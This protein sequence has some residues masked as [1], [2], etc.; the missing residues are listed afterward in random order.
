MLATRLKLSPLYLERPRLLSR[1]PESEG[2]V[3]IL[4]APF[5]YGKSVLAA[6]WADRLEQQGV[7]VVW[8]SLGL[9][10]GPRESLAQ[11]L[12]L[13]GSAPWG[14][15][16]E[17]LANPLTLVVM[18][19]LEGE[20]DDLGPLLRYSQGLLLLASRTSL[21][22]PELLHLA[23]G[24]RLLHLRASDLA[25]TLDEA[26]ALFS[27]P[28]QAESAW[29]A[30][31]GWPLVLH[32][33]ALTGEPPARE[34]LL[35][36]MRQSL[37][38]ALFREALFLAALPYLPHSAV[39]PETE[40]LAGRGFAQALTEGIRLH[41]LVAETLWRAEPERV[42]KAVREEGGR[43]NVLFR[44]YAYERAELWE[45]LRGLLDGLVPSLPEGYLST[46]DPAAFIR[47]DAQVGG[48]RG[49][50]R[51]VRLGESFCRLG[52]FREGVAFLLE[53]AREATAPPR[54]RLE[55]YGMA[56]FF[57]APSHPEEAKAAAEQGLTFL[58]AP[59]VDP[60]LAGRF[61]NDVALVYEASGDRKRALELLEQATQHLLSSTA[62]TAPRMNLA[63]L[64]FEMEGDLEGLILVY[65]EELEAVARYLPQSL[66]EAHLTL[67]RAYKLLAQEE[68]VLKHL[69]AAIREAPRDSL[70]ALEA[71]A[72]WAALRG[73]SE[74]FPALWARAQAW[75]HP[76]LLDRVRGL[77]ARTLRLQGL[78]EEA[79]VVLKDGEGNW[80]AL[81]RALAWEDAAHLPPL[82]REREAQL[83][84]HAARFLLLGT[85][86]DLNALLGL[87]SLGERVLPA[88]LPPQAIASHRPEL[89]RAYP[90]RTLLQGGF[91]EA[92]RQRSH[93]L[94]P[95][96]VWVL[97]RFYIEGPLGPINLSLRLK[98]L[99]GL[100]LL[101]FDAAQLKAALWPEVAPEQARNNLQV[102]LHYLRRALEPWGV[103]T[104]LEEGQLV[105]VKA[106]LE[107]LKSRL[108]ALE[109][110]DLGAA[111]EVLGL[112]QEPLLPGLDL[113]EIDAEREALRARVVRSLMRAGQRLPPEEARVVL[114]RVLE[115]E[116]LEEEALRLLLRSLLDLGRKG[117]ALRYYQRFA[118]RLREELGVEP[119]RETRAL[120]GL[121]PERPS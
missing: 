4:E 115:L 1:L 6:Q 113:P 60:D 58:N 95:L 37:G 79:R 42:K 35:L 41:P 76:A 44:G 121:G 62:R 40:A 78:R 18:E 30:S 53:A 14:V 88:L 3:V 5:G 98:Q 92:I 71:E 25:F 110:G 38:Q 16:L 119:A 66:A 2:S 83:F 28:Q 13:P 102:H 89:L 15:I 81:E 20:S 21:P 91:K 97:G 9:G 112:Y 84:W 12:R 85:E 94:P 63:S 8:V 82:P 118:E 109:R 86:E 101:G 90:L 100:L 17:A 52:R 104:Y 32:L 11:A 61:L 72:E 114:E 96:R 56:A 54:V 47:W 36:G 7:R 64:R 27:D 31:G 46:V 59:D 10:L 120:L 50:R 19:D 80:T 29:R 57:L 77:W 39:R 51:T 107:E 33:T 70:R 111:R 65:E 43:L 34:A 68:L 48:Q 87:T 24:K 26:R 105:R 74:A 69:E 99:F 103:P 75:E 93:E 106:D 67:A 55:A 108:H 117:E 73:S 45:E 23:S 49:P 22:C 116:P